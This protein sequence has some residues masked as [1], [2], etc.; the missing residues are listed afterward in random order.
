[1]GNSHSLLS[2]WLAWPWQNYNS[3]K[4]PKL[5][6]EQAEEITKETGFNKA[7]LN[8]LHDRFTHLDR[9]QQGYLTKADLGKIVDFEV[10]PFKD[11]IF[12]MF[13]DFE[14][15][16]DKIFFEDFCSV[17]AKFQ[18]VGV[19]ATAKDKERVLRERANMLFNFYRSGGLIQTPDSSL[20]G[21]S[22]RTSLGKPS[23]I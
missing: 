9:N 6:S 1:M 8:R 18:P 17:L 10:N 13:T 3:T 12:Q 20:S 5:D 7:T 21:D 4:A 16:K 22:P 14:P 2:S 11:R 19:R 23:K 15:G